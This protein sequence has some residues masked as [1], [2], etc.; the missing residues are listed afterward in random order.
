MIVN[1][2][3]ACAARVTVLGM[4][5]VCLSVCLSVCVSTLFSAL[6]ATKQMASNSNGLSV[7]S[8][9]IIINGDFPETA[10]FKLEKLVVTRSRL[11]GPTH[12]LVL[13]KCIFTLTVLPHP[14]RS[15]V[16]WQFLIVKA[17]SSGSSPKHTDTS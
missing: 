5:T 3:C 17:S 1:P 16:G 9:R 15:V 10:T 8:A 4:C 11:N 6:Q 12:Q 2:W 14:L 7:A 13:R